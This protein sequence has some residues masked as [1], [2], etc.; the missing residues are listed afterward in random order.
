MPTLFSKRFILLA[1]L[2]AGPVAAGILMQKNFKA[3]GKETKGFHA[4]MIGILVSLGIIA[5][6]CFL[7]KLWISTLPYLLIP[8][9]YT[10]AL[11]I[12]LEKHMG[13]ALR[14]HEEADGPFYSLNAY[15]WP[16]FLGGIIFSGMF[17]GLYL[18]SPIKA[19]HSAYYELFEAFSK[20]EQIAL[21]GYDIWNAGHPDSAAQYIATVANPAWDRALDIAKTMDQYTEYDRS[22]GQLNHTI[23]VYCYFRYQYNMKLLRLHHEP[24]NYL[25]AQLLDYQR[26]VDQ[27]LITIAELHQNPIEA[28][29]QKVFYSFMDWIQG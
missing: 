2:F 8:G 1:T 23:K 10:L 6:I 7:P 3:L 16:S 20:E 11:V 18:V 19:N 17:F 5:A 4:L 14:K 15:I 29:K 27:C 26:K 24:S 21:K 12:L 13:D 9:L 25:Q 22:L 28:F